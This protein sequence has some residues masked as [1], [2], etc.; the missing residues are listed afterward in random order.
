MKHVGEKLDLTSLIKPFF[1]QQIRWELEWV[2]FFDPGNI[3][4]K[5]NPGFLFIKFDVIPI[6]F[7]ND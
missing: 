2:E 5:I 4:H 6:D 1:K 7:F 3:G